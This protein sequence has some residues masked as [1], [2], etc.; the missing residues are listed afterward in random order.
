MDLLDPQGHHHGDLIQRRLLLQLELLHL[1]LRLLAILHNLLLATPQA[2]NRATQVFDALLDVPTYLLSVELLL[3]KV[4]NLLEQG[5][6]T[7]RG[8]NVLNFLLVLIV[9]VVII[10]I[11]VVILLIISILSAFAA[12]DLFLEYLCQCLAVRVRIRQHG[13]E[14]AGNAGNFIR[15]MLEFFFFRLQFGLVVTLQRDDLAL[16]GL[17]L[18]LLLLQSGVTAFKSLQQ[19]VLLEQHQQL[20]FGQLQVR[21]DCMTIRAEIIHSLAK[22]SNV[23]THLGQNLSALKLQTAA[24]H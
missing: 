21:A 20:Q 24:H 1:Q 10:V 5:L 13:F 4:E 22:G 16:F 2:V 14:F 17:A 11:V 12:F 6:V 18:D 3:A 15:P 23:L 7:A 9:T 19:L 8:A